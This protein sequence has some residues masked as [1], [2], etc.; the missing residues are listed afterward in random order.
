MISALRHL[1]HRHLVLLRVELGAI[2]REALTLLV[3]GVVVVS[4]LTGVVLLLLGALI[5]ATGDLLYGSP[6][7]GVGLLISILLGL[8]AWIPV[9]LLGV[10][11]GRRQRR[12]AI[13]PA[14]IT[15][16]LIAVG[17]LLA[18]LPEPT[19]TGIATIGGITAFALA[20]AVSLR[21]LDWAAIR[22]RFYPHLSEMELR[23]TLADAEALIA[24]RSTGQDDH[25]D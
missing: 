3:G 12:R 11:H 24:G 19:A 6:Y 16:A 5:V 17:G 21:R 7:L 14:L 25:H 13:L 1:L 4:L 10:D 8:A 9:V 18:G 23:R 2:A 22:A 20:L 15:T